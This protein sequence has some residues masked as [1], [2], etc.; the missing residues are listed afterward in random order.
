[1]LQ[2]LAECLLTISTKMKTRCVKLL[3]NTTR[4]DLVSVKTVKKNMSAY[5][6]LHLYVTTATA[7][8]KYAFLLISC[9]TVSLKV[10]FYLCY[11]HHCEYNFLCKV[12]SICSCSQYVLKTTPFKV[13]CSTIS[14]TLL[15][16][17]CTKR[18]GYQV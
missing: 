13:K 5:T 14:C 9:S 6:L 3:K 11:M 2:C 17:L 15:P 18:D 10:I 12:C 16:P 1:M 4:N 8:F 7:Y